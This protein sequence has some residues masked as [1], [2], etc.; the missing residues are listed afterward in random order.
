VSG[1]STE[2]LLVAAYAA[3][4]VAAAGLLD[5]AARH[6]HARADRFRV[7]GFEYDERLD[8]WRC[9]E[10]EHLQRVETD[11]TARLA[12][13]RARAHVCN[14]CPSKPDCT[15]SDLGREVARP[16]D[17]WPRSEA[18][19]FHRGICLVLLVL[20]ALLLIVEL[21]R[22]HAPGD[23]ALAG[24]MLAIVSVLAVRAAGSFRATPANFPPV[25][26]AGSRR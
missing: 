25:R 20:A 11:L 21:A 16:L 22:R 15:D 9:G 23:A 19:R 17:P 18:G 12:R 14:A 7:A 6:T 3:F 13:Y 5:L 8:A 10:G 1:I 24:G 4:L 2:T 26:P